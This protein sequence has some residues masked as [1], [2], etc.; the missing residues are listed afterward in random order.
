MLFEAL[1]DITTEKTGR[2]LD[3]IDNAVDFSPFI[4]QRF[5]SMVHPAMNSILNQTTNR[6]L[7]HLDKT[8]AYLAFSAIIPRID[9]VPF[10]YFKRKKT[11][12]T[13]DD[14]EVISFLCKHMEISRQVC[15]YYIESYGI[16]LKKMKRVID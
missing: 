16:D 13:Q 6:V 3:D 4:I 2:H 12:Y 14:E 9:K 11:P 10:R 5:L 15:I 8:N 1:E 7:P